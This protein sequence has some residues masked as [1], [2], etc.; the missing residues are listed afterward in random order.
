MW[1]IT[2]GRFTLEQILIMCWGNA[3]YLPQFRWGG[4]HR[5][6]RPLWDAG[7]SAG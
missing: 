6:F 4:W 1:R 3:L 7:Q 2:L 5:G